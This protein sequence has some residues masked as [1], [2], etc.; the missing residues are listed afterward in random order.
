MSDK[1]RTGKNA[2]LY[3]TGITPEERERLE[4]FAEAL[5]RPIGW[6]VRDA[7][8]CYMDSL[9]ADVMALKEKIEATT[10][11]IEKAGET[12]LPGRGRPKA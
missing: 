4:S 11:Q 12:E 3:V 9:E 2:P 6:V 8:K 1:K 10:I 5:G 7:L